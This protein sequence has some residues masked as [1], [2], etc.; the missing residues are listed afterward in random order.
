MTISGA[1]HLKEELHQLK[2]SKRPQVI[3]AIA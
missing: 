2:T 1:E 3:A